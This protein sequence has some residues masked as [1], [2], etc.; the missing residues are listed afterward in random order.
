MTRLKISSSV[1]PDN[2]LTEQEWF[3]TYRVSTRVPK[4]D[5]VDRAKAIMQQWEEER[6]TESIWK[7]VADK[8]RVAG[9]EISS[10]L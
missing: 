2:P 7:A 1:Y 3:D 9:Q 4:Y 6:V 8:I 10:Y 5:G